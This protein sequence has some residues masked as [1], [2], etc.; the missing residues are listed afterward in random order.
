MQ[1]VSAVYLLFF[2]MFVL[3]RFAFDPPTDSMAWHAWLGADGMR[4]A[5]TA[6]SAVLVAHTWVGLSDVVL[7]Y[8]R[9]SPL[10]SPVLA[11]IALAL[12]ALLVWLLRIL[13]SA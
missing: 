11:G 3:A 7:D 9:P 13:I 2:L 8:V 6:F 1:R 4:V 10:R 12:L 5:S